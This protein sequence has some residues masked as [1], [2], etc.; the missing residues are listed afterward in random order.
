MDV[1]LTTCKKEQLPPSSTIGQ[2]VFSFNGII[3]GS[4]VSMVAGINNY[5]MY[6]SFIQD[7]AGHDSVVYGFIGNLQRTSTSR[8]S[9]QFII[10][11]CKYTL[12]NVSV[13]SHIDSSFSRT[14]YYY[15][16]P[17]YDTTGYKVTFTP[18]IYNGTAE[19]FTYSFGD[20]SPNI[21]T[22]NSAP[23][24]HIYTAAAT[25]STSLYVLFS[26]CGS[27]TISNPLT[28]NHGVPHLIID[29]ITSSTGVDSG[30]TLPVF[31]NAVISN[32]TSPYVYSWNF[33]DGGTS[34][35]T[36]TSYT[37]TVNHNY[38]YRSLFPVKLTVTDHFG[39]SQSYNYNVWDTA[40]PSPFCLMDY[41]IST[42]AP[43]TEFNNSLLS[44]IT[45]LYTDANGNIYSS[46]NISQP[47]A[48]YFTISSVSS[49]KNNLSGELTKELTVK[50]SCMLY[51][52]INS[53]SASGTA[54]IAVAYQ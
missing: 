36:S 3:G 7:S 23:V 14:T 12:R 43:V 26:G 44:A 24:T 53:I 22:T 31:F 4:E 48:S 11:D 25:Y 2:P 32:G 51:S 52:G 18:K 35:S 9:I 38:L 20:H 8:S 15:Y 6:S 49:Y 30:G 29:S 37:V 33:G 45:I 21:I 34:T 42:P 5:Y 17:G 50:F 41:R 46:N 1:L 39:N 13:A 28:I 19:A 40:S 10:N 27:D 16:T 54:V 47:S